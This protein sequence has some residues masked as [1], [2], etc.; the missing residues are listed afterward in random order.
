[1]IFERFTP[2]EKIIAT[3][4]MEGYGNHEI[5][6]FLRWKRRTVKNMLS[7]MYRK[8]GIRCGV[9]QVRLAVLLTY[10]RHPELIPWNLSQ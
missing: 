7:G 4:L 5:A 6:R 9:K 10:E 8:A 2:R 3:L 1:V